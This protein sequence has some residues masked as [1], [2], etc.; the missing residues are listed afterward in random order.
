MII[1]LLSSWPDINDDV[2]DVFPGLSLKD[3]YDIDHTT[4]NSSMK[5]SMIVVIRHWQYWL[6]Y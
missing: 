2:D 3:Y 4:T 5:I 6:L 1:H